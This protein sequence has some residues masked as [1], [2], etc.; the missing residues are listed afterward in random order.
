MLY[1]V[2]Q[3]IFLDYPEDGGTYSSE[4]L[5]FIYQA[6]WHHILEDWNLHWHHPRILMHFLLI[7]YNFSSTSLYLQDRMFSDKGM[8][9]FISRSVSGRLHH[10]HSNADCIVTYPALTTV[11]F[12]PLHFKAKTKRCWNHDIGIFVELLQMLLQAIY[13]CGCKNM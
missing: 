7:I 2:E 11:Y 5:V 3:V 6:T 1:R 12:W 10:Y 4:M 8:L 9:L 13:Q